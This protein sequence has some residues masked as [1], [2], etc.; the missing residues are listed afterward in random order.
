MTLWLTRPEADSEALAAELNALGIASIIA[1]V[2][3]IETRDVLLAEKPDALLLTS[4][5]AAH[6]LRAD[7]ADVPVFCV[8]SATAQAARDMGYRA[9]THGPGDALHLLPRITEALPPGSSLLYLSGEDTRHDISRLLGANQIDV[10][11]V[12]A[13]EAVAETSFPTALRLALEANSINGVV[14]FS[15]RSAHLACTLM[16]E[17]EFTASAPAI[18]AFCLSLAVAEE[19]AMLS[20]RSLHVCHTPNRASMLAMIA[21]HAQRVA[22]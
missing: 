5:H 18:D 17:E 14:C 10:T 12:V 3:R 9:V 13:Y 2:V 11:R 22:S 20:W 4:R 15:P 7:W 1:P 6:A 21:A 16:K 8:G 19:A